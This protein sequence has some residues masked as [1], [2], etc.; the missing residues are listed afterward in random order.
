MTLE[1]VKELSFVKEVMEDPRWRAGYGVQAGLYFGE[2]D[3]G[4]SGS[5]REK[6]YQNKMCFQI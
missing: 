5:T 3:L 6:S 2:L 4:C 1:D